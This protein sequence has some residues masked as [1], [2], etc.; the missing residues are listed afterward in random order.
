MI[1]DITGLISDMKDLVSEPPFALRVY[2]QLRDKWEGDRAAQSAT[3]SL[4]DNISVNTDTGFASSVTPAST[5]ET[6]AAME[7]N[8][9]TSAVW[10]LSP[11]WSLRLKR[12]PPRP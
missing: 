3:K 7:T 5:P 4:V 12:W 9:E 8:I 2:D 11:R 6:T 1:R 10:S